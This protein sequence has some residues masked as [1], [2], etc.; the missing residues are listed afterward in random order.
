MGLLNVFI[1]K[2]NQIKDATK[3][4]DLEKT[5]KILLWVA[6]FATCLVVGIYFYEFHS[7]LSTTP[8]DWA[9]FGGYI[10]GVLG[11]FY[12]FLAFIGLLE[13]LRQSRLQ[14]ELEGLL[15]TVQ[16][17]E[18]DLNY[19]ASLTVTCKSPWI[20][21]NDI[22]ASSDIKELPLRTLLESDSI[23]WEQHLM[24][25]RDGLIFRK[26][27]DG[28]LFQDR[29]IWLKAKQATDGLFDYLEL[30]RSKGGEQAV[31]DY[32]YKAYEIPRNR[33]AD[34]DYARA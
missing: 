32:Y 28:T 11:P 4:V 15:H 21:G 29:D 7:S 34:S 26:Q 17:F 20:W 22:E 30:Y 6:I 8:Q 9:S 2:V 23:D 31:C 27:A 33:L 24:E 1:Q 18:K 5:L 10:G 16:Q 12:A 14:R 3:Y 13:T 19:C 25:L